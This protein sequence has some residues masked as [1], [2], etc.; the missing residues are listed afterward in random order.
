MPVSGIVSGSVA[1]QTR[2]SRTRVTAPGKNARNVGLGIGML[3]VTQKSQNWPSVPVT[4]PIAFMGAIQ[5]QRTRPP[6]SNSLWKLEATL[7]SASATTIPLKMETYSK[8]VMQLA[9]SDRDSRT[10][11][12]Y[13]ARAAED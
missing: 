5:C 1:A 11:K 3:R 9:P 7:S 6:A 13:D 8:R 2:Y 4:A 10:S 12:G